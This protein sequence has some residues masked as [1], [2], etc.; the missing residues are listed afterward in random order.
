LTVYGDREM[1]VIRE[2]TKKFEEVQ[3]GTVSHLMDYYTQNGLPKGEL[4]LVIAGADESQNTT[5]IDWV[6]LIQTVRP[7]YSVKEAATLLSKKTGLSKKEI[8]Q[9]ILENEKK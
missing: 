1:A 6:K 2:I 7:K 3:K 5:A 8:Y 4:V 9:R